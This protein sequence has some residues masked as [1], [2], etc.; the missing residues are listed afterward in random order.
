MAQKTKKTKNEE[1]TN[2]EK[3]ELES[4]LKRALADYQNLERRIEEERRV[5]GELSSVIL[6]EKF[7]PVLDNLENAQKHLNDQGLD[8]VIKQFKD[9]LASEGLEEVESEG[10]EFNPHLHEAVET[11]EGQVDNKIMKVVTKGYKIRDRVIRPA[12]VIVAKAKQT[13][14]EIQQEKMEEEFQQE[15]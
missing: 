15:S 4:Q 2:S 3:Q 8:L 5:L 1:K 13:A 11:E 9:I 6:I 10:V 7:L 14:D 12:K